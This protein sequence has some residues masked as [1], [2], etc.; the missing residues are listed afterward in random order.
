MKTFKK[1]ALV[2][3]IAA[4]PFMA[5]AELVSMD[6]A[7]MGET[8]GQAGVT[9]D[10]EIGSAGLTVGSVVYTDEGSVNIN[11]ISVT[12]KTG[13]IKL[14]QTIDILANGDLQMVTSPDGGSQD[15]LISVA[16]IQLDGTNGKAEL[17][18]N[19]NIDMTLEGSSTTT[20]H[21][22]NFATETLADYVT[23]AAADKVGIVI[24][25]G[26]SF[27]INDLD[28]G[29]FGYTQDQADATYNSVAAQGVLTGALDAGD[30]VA[31]DAVTGDA[32]ITKD[33]AST[34]DYTGVEAD[35]AAA[36]G[37][38]KASNAYMAG[39]SA[40]Q[41]NDLTMDNDGNAIVM[42]QQIWASS[43]GVSIKISQL[44]ADIN[45]GGI[46]IGGAS[47][48]SLAINDLS[49]AGLTSTISGH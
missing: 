35:Y 8:T 37:T 16:D 12:P 9:I 7:L 26:A 39:T 24:D 27:K 38:A 6:E 30:T 40:I 17:L 28:V 29:I 47:I 42:N 4:A 25:A 19:L 13:T 44:D 20:I 22:V 3:A 45:I 5:Q 15:L 23:G 18:S 21:N 48:G 43:A 1:I 14:S 32:T 10:L 36:N 41:I 11:G 2:S 31:Y 46:V 34:A 33:A 49:L